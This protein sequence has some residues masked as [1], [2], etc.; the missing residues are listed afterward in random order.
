MVPRIYVHGIRGYN[1]HAY[2]LLVYVVFV[3]GKCTCSVE[4]DC[5]ATTVYHIY[6]FQC[7][8]RDICELN[9]GRAPDVVVSGH[10]DLALPYV[11]YVLEYIIKELLKNSMK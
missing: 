10:T 5:I 4:C 11:P 7:V 3:S 9:Y 2:C 6:V 8:D 1:G